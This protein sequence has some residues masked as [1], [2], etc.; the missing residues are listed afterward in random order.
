MNNTEEEEDRALAHCLA[1]GLD[2]IKPLVDGNA[3]EVADQHVPQSRQMPNCQ[4][5]N[6]KGQAPLVD[7]QWDSPV[8]F[9]FQV[10]N[11]LVIIIALCQ[12]PAWVVLHDI[13]QMR[14]WLGYLLT[15][16]DSFC[17]PSIAHRVCLRQRLLRIG[18]EARFS[19]VA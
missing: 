2:R 3:V 6:A 8:M 14:P 17:S 4:L 7:K 1:Y 12:K 10:K 11:V 5:A 19:A 16:A 13:V 9:I 18:F 15:R